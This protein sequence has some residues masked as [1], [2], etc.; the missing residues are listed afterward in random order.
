MKV[1]LLVLIM[2][3]L[4]CSC[5][6]RS[7][8][9]SAKND[10]VV[11]QPS[12]KAPR[13]LTAIRHRANKIKKELDY[14]L[15]RHDELD[16]GY[17]QVLSYAHNERLKPST[18]MP[19]G[20]L[21]VCNVGHWRCMPRS[22]MG[23]TKDCIGRYVVA[24]FNADT[25]S[26]GLRIDS[27]GVYA[28][29][30][31]RNGLPSGHGFYRGQDNELYDGQWL[32]GV[33]HGFGLK[34]SPKKVSAGHWRYGKFL[35]ERMHYT[36]QR[37]YGIDL[38]RYQHEKKRK[39]YS[40]DWRKMRISSLGHR[41]S[42]N[43]VLGRVDY[44]VSFVYIKSTE[45]ISIK[46]KY[47]V[48]DYD[49]ARRHGIHAGAYHFFS[50]R[51]SAIAQANYFISNS[52]FRRG[53]LPPMLDIEPSDAQI[54]AMGG[55]E[56]LFTAMRAWLDYV[57]RHLSV[58]PIIYVNQRFVEQYIPLA[59]DLKSNYQLWVARYSVYKPDTHLT[60]WQLSADGHVNGI[61]PEVDIN[62][63]NGYQNQWE[64]FLQE[65]TVK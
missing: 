13:D 52:R 26:S 58:R 30:L 6:D 41:A 47:F 43:K 2:S 9:S 1:L 17:D 7:E 27:T 59:P 48:S 49:A 15:E 62:V 37:I 39:T 3:M 32:G 28:G 53:D 40:I 21:L 57:E 61:V 44:P 22:G 55:A 14:Y 64:Q 20:Q 5:G 60:F 8:P 31:D 56:A 23:V 4:C 19:Y 24:M 38:A 42:N 35:G 34:L 54:A 18:Y 33:R 50:T 25:L 12:A 45:G 11:E 65:A 29:H 16:E 46:N 36:P 10:P 51:Q 63:F